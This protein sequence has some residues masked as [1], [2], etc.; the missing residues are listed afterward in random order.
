MC[1][2]IYQPKAGHLKKDRAERLWGQNPDGAGFAYV[3]DG[4]M[5]VQKY[6]HFNEFWR[7]F[8]RTR[9]RLPKRTS[10]ST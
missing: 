10:S 8:E 9:S 7:A 1:V 2:L 3:E 6:M 4:E 5:Q